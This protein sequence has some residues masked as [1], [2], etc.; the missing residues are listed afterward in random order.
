MQTT[1]E[2]YLAPTN[3]DTILRVPW[4]AQM[5]TSRAGRREKHVKAMEDGAEAVLSV[6][7]SC[8]LIIFKITYLLII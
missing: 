4:S 1:M 5:V 7:V 3:D 2:N 6:R 8:N